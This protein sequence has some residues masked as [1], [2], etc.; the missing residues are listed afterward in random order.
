MKT[1]ELVDELIE[2]FK[3]WTHDGSHG[4]LRYLDQAHTILMSQESHQTAAYSMQSGELPK[5]ETAAEVR[6]YTLP[7][8]IWRVG[9]VLLRGNCGLPGKEVTIAGEFFWSVSSVRTWD[10]L[11]HDSPA[12]VSFTIDPG[13]RTFYLR[14]WVRPTP[15]TSVKI[16][17]QIPPP[18]DALYLLPAAAKLIEGVQNGDAIEARRFVEHELKPKFWASMNKGE[19]SEYIEPVS[20]GF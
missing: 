6:V 13:E 9:G 8:N 2:R 10:W 14:A 20:R 7:H 3:G 18:N 19:Q 16:P 1:V 4:V 12:R 5:L 15:L 17:H 11:S